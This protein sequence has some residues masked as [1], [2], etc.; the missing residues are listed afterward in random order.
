MKAVSLPNHPALTGKFPLVCAPLV[1]RDRAT[2]LAEA[3]AVAA[4]GPDLLEWRVDFFEGIDRPAEVAELTGA[5]K[6][7]AGGLPLLFTRR[8]AREGGEAIA[9]AEAQVLELYAAVCA[10]GEIDL[11]DYEMGHAPQDVATVCALARKHGVGLVLSFHNFEQT[12][13]QDALA[14]KFR[15]AQELGAD[16]AKVAV[17]PRRM[18]D[19]LTL[20]AATLEASQALAIP[21]VSMAMGALGATT[22]ICGSAFGSAL[23]FAVGQSASAP[24]QMPIADLSAALALLR[25]AGAAA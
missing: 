3:A 25:K 12:P 16:V 23:T 15:L 20:L 2:L 21:V 4:R 11:I 13:A 14:A 22:R 19:V 24:G 7:A 5:L 6:R 8:W 18:E 1:G 9:L 17:M 10:A